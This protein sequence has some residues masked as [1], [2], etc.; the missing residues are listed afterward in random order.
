MKMT[1]VYAIV[2]KKRIAQVA[3]IAVVIVESCVVATAVSAVRLAA[4]LFV[5]AACRRVGNAARIC[6]ANV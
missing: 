5:V 6:V 2:A 1:G 3:S 4:E